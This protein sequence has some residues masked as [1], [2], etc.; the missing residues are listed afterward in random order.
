MRYFFILLIA[1]FISCHIYGPVVGP[2][3]ITPIDKDCAG[4]CQHLRDLGCE[5][6]QPLEDG[7][8]CE[9]F[10]EA[11]IKNG[12]ALRPSCIKTLTSCDPVEMEKCQGPR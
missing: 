6:G 5:E 11:T 8:S 3:P 1:F 10:C 12:H 4:A 9:T 7:T 2:A